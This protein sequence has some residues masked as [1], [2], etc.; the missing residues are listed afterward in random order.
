MC[1]RAE[2]ALSTVATVTEAID[3]IVA[4]DLG[5]KIGEFNVSESNVG[6]P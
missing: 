2:F 6:S 5:E 3:K 1:W 4:Y